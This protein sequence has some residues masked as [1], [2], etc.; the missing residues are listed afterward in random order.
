MNSYVNAIILVKFVQLIANNVGWN[1]IATVTSF[2]QWTAS[3]A[4]FSL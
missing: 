4:M 2:I 3:D 1:R